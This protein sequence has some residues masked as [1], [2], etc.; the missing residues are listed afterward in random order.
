MN[1]CVPEKEL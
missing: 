1:Y